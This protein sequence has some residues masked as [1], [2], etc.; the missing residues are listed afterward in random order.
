MKKITSNKICKK[1]GFKKRTKN[2]D[3]GQHHQKGSG[4]KLLIKRNTY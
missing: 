3:E 4:G 2:H 1:C